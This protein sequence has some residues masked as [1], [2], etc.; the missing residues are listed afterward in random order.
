MN[1]RDAKALKSHA[2]QTPTDLTPD[3]VRDISGA[4]NILLADMFGLYLKTK[5]VRSALS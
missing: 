3:A 5:N 1:I 4:L 2:L